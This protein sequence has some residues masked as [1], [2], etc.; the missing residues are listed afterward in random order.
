MNW[1]GRNVQNLACA[2]HVLVWKDGSALQDCSHLE[3]YV[4]EGVELINTD[5]EWETDCFSCAL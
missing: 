3:G 2:E 4:C 1:S 5:P